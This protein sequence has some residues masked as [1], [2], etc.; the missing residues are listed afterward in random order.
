MAFFSKGIE[1]PKKGDSTV[2]LE[3]PPPQRVI[4]PLKQYI[5]DAAN[6]IVKVGDKVKAGQ[7][8]ATA[9]TENS[10]PLYAT[11]SGEIT[12]ISERL[13]HSGKS[14]PSIII[15]SDGS[16]TWIESTTKE[17]DIST[18]DS[19]EILKRIHEAGLV[20]KGLAPV[21]LARDLIPMDQ[22]KTLLSL[23]GREI[24]K[25]IDTIIITALD[26]EPSL[27]T[28]RYLASIHHD[29]LADG[30]A[31]LRAI[32]GAEKTVFI[33][34]KNNA[35]PSQIL[36]I[37]KD[38]EE[39]TTKVIKLD[40]SR[41]P[42]GLP[43]PM[44]K[45]VLGREVPLPYGH[46]R[47]VG[48]AIY[49]ID[50]VISIGKSVRKQIPQT[51]SLITVGGKALSRH[52]V[53][54][55]RIGVETGELIELLGGFCQG[56]AK[57]ILGGPMMGTAQYD[58]SVPITKDVTGLFALTHDEIQLVGDYHECIN[59]GLCVK[60]CPVNLVPGTLSMYCAKNRFD[61]SERYGLF[62]CIECGCCDYV[63]P[64]TRPMVHLFRYA[65]HQ[66]MECVQ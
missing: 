58:L 57:I 15:K 37:L 28:N 43:I 66:L 61:M 51:E 48:V 13:D 60:V 5:G 41:Y 9:D 62:S 38:D 7:L 49:D 36:D 30:I 11:I 53:I 22:P 25:K 23:T 65:K 27:L 17:T 33:V 63:C 12:D 19:S 14:I 59:C 46:P 45:A 44:V 4:L 6:P 21:S 31:S 26:T 50:S 10:L 16:D 35:P 24:V 52:G 64:S 55:I 29:E 18:L 47:D 32:T 34:D 40:I 20:I 42:T 56:P 3:I 1:L 39:E 54:K 8:I 2:L